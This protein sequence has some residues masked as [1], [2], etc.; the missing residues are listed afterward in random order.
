MK[1]ARVTFLLATV[2]VFT[3]LPYGLCAEQSDVDWNA[4]GIEAFGAGNYAEARS[5][6]D[7]AYEVEKKP[8]Y[9]LNA[10]LSL[11]RQGQYHA[12]AQYCK[13][14]LGLDPSPDTK[15]KVESLLS[16]SERVIKEDLT[17]RNKHISEE[18][19]WAGYAREQQAI[20]RQ[21]AQRKAESTRMTDQFGATTSGSTHEGSSTKSERGSD[22][23]H[24]DGPYPP[25]YWRHHR[26]HEHKD[27]DHKDNHHEHKGGHHKD[28]HH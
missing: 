9:L 24:E 17:R 22:Y 21:K 27:G 19:F 25:E 11:S 10:A 26:H 2:F 6:F 14:A 8:L 1:R 7:K 4:R 18:K 13:R 16:R 5:H 3:N 23:T 15:N 20:E 12:V 28:E